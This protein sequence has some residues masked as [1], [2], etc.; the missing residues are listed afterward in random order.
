VGTVARA[1]ESTGP[2]R[3]PARLF[4]GLGLTERDRRILTLASR[5][6]GSSRVDF[7]EALKALQEAAEELIPAGRVYVLGASDLGPIVRLDW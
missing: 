7:D 5:K 6:L 3:R 2:V 4:T 1:T